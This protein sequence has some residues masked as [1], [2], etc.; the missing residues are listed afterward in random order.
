MTHSS[1]DAYPGLL[2]WHSKDLVN[3]TP[4]VTRP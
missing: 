1:F 3:W 2:I 4:V